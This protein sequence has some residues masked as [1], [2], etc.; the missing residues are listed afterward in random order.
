MK[1]VLIA[2]APRK[3]SEKRRILYLD[4]GSGSGGSSVSLVRLLK[5]LDRN[6]WTPVVIT[7]RVGNMTEEMLTN[8]IPVFPIPLRPAD[9]EGGLLRNIVMFY[10]PL[11]FRLLR[12]FREIKPD[13]IHLNNSP[14]EPLVAIW[15][16]S[17]L[18][19]PVVAHLRTTR[20]LTRIELSLTKRLK[21]LIV[22]SQMVKKLFE[23]QDVPSGKIRYIPDGIEIAH[24][25]HLPLNAEKARRQ[26]GILNS[27]PVI[28]VVA[29][30]MPKKGQEQFIR[31]MAKVVKVYPNVKA[32]ILGDECET[33][34]NYLSFLK[35][36]VSQEELSGNIQF[37]GWVEKPEDLYPAFDIVT[38]TSLLQEGL[39]SVCLEAMGIGI[40]VVSTRVGAVPELVE[41]GVAGLLVPPGDADAMAE[42][43]LQLLQDERKRLEMGE[44]ARKRVIEHFNLRKTKEKMEA[45]YEE[46]TQKR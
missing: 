25:E 18:R 14:R 1:K 36:M 24:H 3:S 43:L 10:I 39:P 20:P 6:R 5:V 23:G 37:T 9:R 32:V 12:E 33:H 17:L 13:V 31:A 46:V 15:A 42:A 28:G 2:D 7:H 21:A 16:A 29:R 26:L 27:E 35:N 44:N 22:L 34:S 4:A 41:E 45:L 8:G 38:Q 30:L 40:P 19:I 11:F